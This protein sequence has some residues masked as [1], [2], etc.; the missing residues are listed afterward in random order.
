MKRNFLV[1][2]VISAVLFSCSNV[3]IAHEENDIHSELFKTVVVKD[4]MDLDIVKCV[5]L[6]FQNSPK[7]KHSKYEL[8]L[9]KS[10]VGRAKSAFFPV[11]GAGVGFYNQNNSNSRVY[12]QYYRELPSVAVTVNQLVWDFGKSTANIKMEEFYKIGAEYEF[13][14]SLCSTL[15]DV[16][17]KYYEVLKAQAEVV[18]AEDNVIICKKYLKIA[19]GAPDKTTASYQLSRALFDLNYKKTLLKN[20]K[21]NLSNAMFIENTNYNLANTKT[22]DYEHDYGYEKQKKPEKFKPYQFD[23]P[24]SKAVE[25]AYANSP[26][27]K[28]LE[29]TRNAMEQNLKYI[30]RTYLPEL[31]A[32]AGYGFVNNTEASTNHSMQV[33]VNLSTSVNLMNLKHSIKG[34]DAQLNIADNEINLFK[35]DLYFEIQ[36]A[37]NNIEFAIDDVPYAQITA[38]KALDNLNLV[39]KQYLSGELNYVALQDARKDYVTAANSYITSIYFYNKSLIQVEEALHCHLI[40]IHHK[41]QHAMTNHADEL[42][43]HLND[44]LNC[45]GKEKPKKRWKKSKDNL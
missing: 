23:F 5:A 35:K 16:K 1:G 20:A 9:A 3:C 17:T 2:I 45:E 10:N 38:V 30:K 33:G 29:S 24:K 44:A 27:L 19:K 40:D 25:I 6:A 28:V 42:L 21:V 36:K 41:G 22:F 31:A 43:E 4:G 18:A 34:A 7:I 26:D 12:D 14:D 39:E 32:N 11:I 13:I 37:F 8:D 15:F